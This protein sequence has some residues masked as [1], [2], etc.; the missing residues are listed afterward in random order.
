MSQRQ[1]WSR[2]GTQS[3]SSCTP[4][5]RSSPGAFASTAQWVLILITDAGC[6]PFNEGPGAK[7]PDTAGPQSCA[8]Q[9][10][11]DEDSIINYRASKPLQPWLTWRVLIPD[12]SEANVAESAAAFLQ[13]GT[14]YPLCRSVGQGTWQLKQPCSPAPHLQ[15]LPSLPKS[16]S[17]FHTCGD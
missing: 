9:A 13:M 8:P 6:P 4:P 10:P 15:L 16:S 2:A 14:A 11:P 1:G 17:P 3:L 5:S 7:Q 12:S